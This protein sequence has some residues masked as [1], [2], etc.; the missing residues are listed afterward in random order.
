MAEIERYCC[1]YGG[2]TKN[3]TVVGDKEC[4][5]W[6]ASENAFVWYRF[7]NLK[8][9]LVFFSRPVKHNAHEQFGLSILAIPIPENGFHCSK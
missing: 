2:I 5:D 9:F 4:V 6:Y 8:E 3:L 1:R 7:L